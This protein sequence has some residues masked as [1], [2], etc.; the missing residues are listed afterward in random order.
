VN[1]QF[2]TP[3]FGPLFNFP[4]RHVGNDFI[5]KIFHLP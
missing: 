4:E 2:C 3:E 1:W 5:G